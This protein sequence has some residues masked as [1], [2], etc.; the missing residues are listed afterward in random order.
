VSEIEFGRIDSSANFKIRNIENVKNEK[1]KKYV[2]EFVGSV[3]SNILKE[4]DKTI[5]RS[6]LIRE[7]NAEKWFREMLYDEYSNLLARENF[8]S[9]TERILSQLSLKSYNVAVDK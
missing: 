7:N 6:D 2:G 1:L 5:L 3:F 9:V 4:M 8:K